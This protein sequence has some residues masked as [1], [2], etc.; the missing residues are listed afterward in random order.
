MNL[1][2]IHWT[3]QSSYP[4]L[5]ALQLLPLLAI[6]LILSLRGRTAAY[7]TAIGLAVAELLLAFDLYRH[8]DPA[9][10]AMQL[11]EQLPLLPLLDYHAAV[12]G[13]GVLFILLTA[14]LSL[15][16]VLYAQVRKLAN[17]TTFLAMVFAI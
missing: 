6:V 16:L 3:A 9:E 2:E 4:I 17:S 15:L 5:A 11:A 14:V 7:P 8:F 12:D 13:M 10:S 1:A